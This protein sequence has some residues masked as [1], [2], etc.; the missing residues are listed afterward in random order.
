MTSGVCPHW[1]AAWE[2]GLASQANDEQANDRQAKRVCSPLLV[3]RPLP[4]PLIRASAPL[5]P[6]PPRVCKEHR[7][8]SSALEKRERWDHGSSA[9]TAQNLLPRF[10]LQTRST[11]KAKVAAGSYG[12]MTCMKHITMPC[13]F[14][15][16]ARRLSAC[17]AG[18][19]LAT[20]YVRIAALARSYV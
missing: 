16:L 5:K 6:Q 9:F 20:T 11:T 18:V 19:A 8:R 1:L 4:R 13:L 15:L 2:A 12:S 3:R 14:F 17:P 7:G 10:S